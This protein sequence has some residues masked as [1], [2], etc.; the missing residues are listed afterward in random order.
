MKYSKRKRW[1]SLVLCLCLSLPT[2]LVRG[3]EADTTGLCPH[4]P[5]HTEDCG[6]AAGSEGAPCTHVHEESCYYVA[7]CIHAH[8]GT[9]S[10][11]CTH[12]CSVESGCLTLVSTCRHTHDETCGYTPATEEIP[13]THTHDDTCG[14][15]PETDSP[16]THIC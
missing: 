5:A 7:Q 15:D 4:H 13:C 12:V 8:D 3:E 1:L 16:C 2:I 10:S 14:Y 6:Y 9:C 11:P